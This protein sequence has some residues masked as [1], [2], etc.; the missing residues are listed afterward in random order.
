MKTIQLKL[1]FFLGTSIHDTAQVTAAGMNYAEIFKDQ[2][3]FDAAITTKLIRNSF[4]VIAIPILAIMLNNKKNTKIK[5]L[6]DKT[7]SR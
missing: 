6:I 3:V 5:K 1:E 4:L 7:S 2:K